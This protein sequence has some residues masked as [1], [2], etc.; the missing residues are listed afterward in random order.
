MSA[1]GNI[2]LVV[3][4]P[5]THADIVRETLGIAGA[6]KIGNYDFCS[7]SVRGTGRFKGNDAA[8]PAVGTKGVYES[9]EEDR[10]EVV[11]PRTILEEVISA[12][13]KVHPY[14]EMA[15]DIYPL[16]DLKL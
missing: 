4:A 8:N 13:K 5:V 9:V 3:F 12:V 6:G 2:K 10:I 15:Y 1:S 16:E 7:F 14:E 11:V